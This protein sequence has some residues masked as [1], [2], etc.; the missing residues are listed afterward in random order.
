[1]LK[2]KLF[3]NNVYLGLIGQCNYFAFG[4]SSSPCL[5]KSFVR[6]RANWYK[7]NKQTK[8]QT[9]DD[10]NAPCETVGGRHANIN[11]DF[12]CFFFFFLKELIVVYEPFDGNVV[13]M[14]S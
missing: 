7:T 9:K 5:T 8:K 1:M 14:G 11:F 13:F 6:A 12:R 4:L 2:I 3:S 10:V